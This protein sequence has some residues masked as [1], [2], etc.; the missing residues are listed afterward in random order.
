[1]PFN[2][3]T[4]RKG[5]PMS[6][7]ATT[8][9]TAATT[10]ETRKGGIYL[11]LVP[12]VLFSVLAR[13]SID[14]AS[15]L[16]LGAAVAIAVP[17]IRAG[18]PKML[19]IGTAATFAVFVVVAFSVDAHSAAWVARYARAFAA[20][21]LALI[22]FASL[23]FVPFTE[24]YAHESVPQHLWHTPTFKAVNRRLTAMWGLVFAAMIPL[25][26][27]AGAAHA[28]PAQIVLNWVLPLMLV[29]WAVK[30][31]EAQAQDD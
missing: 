24:Q 14:A 27:A 13:F 16:A 12:W 30:R 3:H 20:G 25:H 11:A 29:L 26:V 31:S 23:M 8:T 17:G 9:V 18:R 5:N 21:G 28:R 7:T 19:E 22:A 6:A 4:I 10:S 2:G 15:V 1:M